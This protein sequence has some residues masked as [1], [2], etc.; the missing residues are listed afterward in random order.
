MVNPA[1]AY[2]ETEGKEAN[3]SA[4]GTGRNGGRSG[5]RYVSV[6]AENGNV[7]TVRGRTRRRPGLKHRERSDSY[8]KGWKAGVTRTARPRGE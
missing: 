1:P 6:R 5:G 3:K 8:N 7:G 2:P 4:T